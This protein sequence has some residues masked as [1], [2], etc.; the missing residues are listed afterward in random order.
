MAVTLQPYYLG[1]LFE[2]CRRLRNRAVWLVQPQQRDKSRM[3]GRYMVISSPEAIRRA[4][5]LSRTAELSAA[6][7][8]GADAADPD[9]AHGG[10]PAPIRAGALG[11]D[12]ALGQGPADIHAADQ[13]ARRIRERQA[14]LSQSPCAGAA[15]WFPADGFYEWKDEGGRKRP[16]CVRPKDRRA[17]R[18]RRPVG[19]LD[20]D[21][22]ARRWRP[23]PSS[24]PTPAAISPRMHDRM[25]VIV[26]PDAFDFWLDCRNVD[27]TTATAL[28][29]PA[30]RRTARCLRGFARGQSRGERRAGIDRAGLVAAGRG[31]A[32]RRSRRSRA[33]QTREEA[34]EGR[35][36]VV[37]VLNGRPRRDPSSATMMRGHAHDVRATAPCRD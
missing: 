35:P 2:R 6:L 21:R 17:D 1:A 37:A 25:P 26:P 11:A 4:V 19:D 34:E 36:A 5:R 20:R 33:G 3:C 16:Y 7:Q 24:P 14:G 31:P 9:R 10:G 18:F 12:S 28:L 23:P 30:A 8:R 22:T 29:A 13:C 32:R 15:A 27:A